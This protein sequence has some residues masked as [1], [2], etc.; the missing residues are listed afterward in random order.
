MGHE[1]FRYRK[2]ITG[3]IRLHKYTKKQ[4]VVAQGSVGADL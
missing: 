2:I 3:K 4:L 1:C